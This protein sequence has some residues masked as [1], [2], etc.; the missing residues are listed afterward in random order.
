MNPHL[1]SWSRWMEI[2]FVEVDCGLEFGPMQGGPREPHVNV[3]LGD[4][5]KPSR[6][7]AQGAA[8][9]SFRVI[10]PGAPTSN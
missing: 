9:Y 10:P 4:I 1:R 7:K 5:G 3:D 6:R 8:G 2:D